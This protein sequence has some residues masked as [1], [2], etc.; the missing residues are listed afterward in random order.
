MS[1]YELGQ[2]DKA[3]YDHGMS[4]V[5]EMRDM[6]GIKGGDTHFVVI[7]VY[8]DGYLQF[9]GA[10]AAVNV[11]IDRLA[12]KQQAMLILGRMDSHGEIDVSK[13]PLPSEN[14]VELLDRAIGGMR[15]EPIPKHRTDHELL[16]QYA[17]RIET[18][19]KNEARRIERIVRDAI[20]GYQ[21][22]YANAP[23][24]DTEREL[25]ERATVANE[26]LVSHGFEPEKTFWGKEESP[27]L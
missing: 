12:A 6:T 21:D 24:D 19:S 1:R 25:K 5:Q 7:A 2:F 13:A 16:M 8:A 26:W 10:N 4:V 27:C 23:N 9:A 20:I 17:D 22:L 18:A 14:K 15:Y 11:H 3:A